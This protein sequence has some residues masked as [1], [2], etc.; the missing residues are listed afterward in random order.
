VKVEIGGGLSP[1]GPPWINVDRCPTADRVVDLEAGKL[2]FDDA[3]VDAVY[4]A[5]CFEHIV[6]LIGLLREVGRVCKSGALV[7]IRVPHYL[8]AMAMCH[9]HKQVI[10]PEQIEH[11]C[12]TAI[13]YWW[14]DCP[15][16]L[17]LVGTETIRGGAFDAAQRCF[18]WLT[19]EELMRFCPGA[20]HEIRYSFVVIPNA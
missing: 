4:S 12:E 11:W 1:K 9:D 13:P 20:A 5:H 19:P 2:P 3:S 8:S 6:N 14:G 10:P 7:E 15:R 17:R 16:R 18:Q